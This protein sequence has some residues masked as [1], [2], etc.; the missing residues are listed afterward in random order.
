M[1]LSAISTRAV[2]SAFPY[3]LMGETIMHLNKKVIVPI[4]RTAIR[5]KDERDIEIFLNNALILLWVWI[6]FKLYRNLWY[7]SKFHWLRK[8]FD[9][10]NS[11]V[12]ARSETTWRS[13]L[14]DEMATLPLVTRH[15][16]VTSFNV[17]ILFRS[18]MGRKKIGWAMGGAL[19]SLTGRKGLKYT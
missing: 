16:N 15:D 1:K 13:L 11:R 12:I 18:D 5:K 19:L 4:K 9:Q 3:H 2:E 6:Q 7:L 17:P 8:Y 14:S 10:I